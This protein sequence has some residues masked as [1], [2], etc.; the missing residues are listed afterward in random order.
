MYM[1]RQVTPPCTAFL[2]ALWTIPSCP[3]PSEKTFLTVYVTYIALE[4]SWIGLYTRRTATLRPYWTSKFSVAYPALLSKAEENHGLLSTEVFGVS[5]CSAPIID[6]TGFAHDLRCN[7]AS[8]TNKTT[9]N[10]HIRSEH[11]PVACGHQGH[12]HTKYR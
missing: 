11:M 4:R 6:T 7:L 8:V 9:N 2:P 10:L 1:G 3:A 5:I 12:H